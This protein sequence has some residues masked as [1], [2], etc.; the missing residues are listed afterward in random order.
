MMECIIHQ[1]ISQDD[2]DE[3]S[4]SPKDYDSWNTLLEAVKV[5]NHTIILYDVAKDLR[6]NEVP[7][8]HYHRKCRS[9]FT[10]KRDLDTLKKEDN[11]GSM[12]L[13]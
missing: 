11:T 8:I 1:K 2:E 4:V 12:A 7:T 10:M 3:H 9:I 6:E 5:R 13:W